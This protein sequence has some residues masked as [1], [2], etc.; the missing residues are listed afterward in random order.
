MAG[1]KLAKRKPKLVFSRLSPK[2][3]RIALARDVLKWLP[4]KRFV[5]ASVYCEIDPDERFGRLGPLDDFQEVLAM[6]RTTCTVCG[7]GA[8]FISYVRLFDRQCFS[9]SLGLP[10]ICRALKSTFGPLQLADIED[11]FEFPWVS[12][13][14]RIDE[15]KT[16]RREIAKNIIRNDG[17]FVLDDVP[18]KYLP[19]PF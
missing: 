9:V 1:T 5:C 6:P 11:A 15:A 19:T 12:N 14:C 10:Q 17:K 16:R 2:E 3:R 18:K 7:I 4:L 13:Y 8:M